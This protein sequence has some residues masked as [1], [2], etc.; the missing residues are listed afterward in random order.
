MAKFKINGKIVTG[1]ELLRIA[2]K[3]FSK[4]SQGRSRYGRP[5][6]ADGA[7]HFLT[8]GTNRSK[9]KVQWYNSKSKKF[10]P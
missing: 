5:K 7:Y 9:F 6:T 10:V 3:E 2:N 1:S 4:Y 8:S